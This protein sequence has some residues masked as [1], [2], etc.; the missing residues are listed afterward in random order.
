MNNRQGAISVGCPL[1]GKS[2]RAINIT[3]KT[4]SMLVYDNVN[5]S[6]SVVIPK[7]QI[8]SFDCIINHSNAIEHADD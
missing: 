1:A 8:D 4:V 3:A 6:L 2:F 7:P 5:L